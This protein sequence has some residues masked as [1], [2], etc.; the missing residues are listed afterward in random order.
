MRLHLVDTN[1]RLV[2]AWRLAF[3]ECK[4]VSIQQEDILLIAENTLVS[5]ANSYGYMDGGIDAHYRSFFGVQIET[6]VQEAIRRRPEGLLPVEQA[7][8][9]LQVTLAFLTLSWR[10]L[11]RFQSRFIASIATGPCEPY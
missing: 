2:E 7:L 3:K 10:R 11:W 5:P 4:E 1:E 9:C 8:S 6:I